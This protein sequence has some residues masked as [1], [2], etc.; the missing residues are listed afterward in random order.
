MGGGR[1]E[2]SCGAAR[3][4]G[5]CDLGNLRWPVGVCQ[6]QV[7]NRIAVRMRLTMSTSNPFARR[8]VLM[9]GLCLATVSGFAQD[10]AGQAAYAP[11]ETSSSKPDASSFSV[12]GTV[13][14]SVTGEPIRRAA[15]QVSGQNFSLALTDQGGHFVI[16]GLAEGTAVLNAVKP[17]FFDEEPQV[18]ARVGKDAP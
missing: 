13:I 4:L 8:G 16:D 5:T 14:N 2:T 1:L 18:P 17:G 12:S 9:L 10:P 3:D 7:S 15:V 6:H 11:Y